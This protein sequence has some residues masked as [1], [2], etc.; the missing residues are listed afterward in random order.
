MDP[1]AR[2]G[3]AESAPPNG[4][5]KRENVARDPRFLK[6]AGPET[7]E[8]GYLCHLVQ[9]AAQLLPQFRFNRLRTA[10]WKLAKVPV[11][12]GSLIMGDLYLSGAG[13]WA[14][15]FSVGEQTYITG[16]VRVNLGGA[17]RIGSSVN[18]GHDCLFLTVDHHVGPPWRRAGASQYGTIVVE[19]GAWIASRVTVLPGVTIGAGAIVAAGSVVAAHVP[20]HT[21]VG[22]VPAKVIRELD[23]PA[24]FSRSAAPA[25]SVR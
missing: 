5:G 19:D 12:E 8:I 21:M 4:S 22:G 14:S 18:I 17:L 16:P 1:A 15:L 6:L 7:D 2:D 9:G 23:P 3:A 20:P 25:P 10:L 24:A 13:D 11:G